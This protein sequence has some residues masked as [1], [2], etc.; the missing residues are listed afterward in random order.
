M[1]AFD[2]PEYRQQLR[3]LA[4]RGVFIGTSSWKYPGWCGQIYD[5]QRYLTRDKFSESKFNRECLA[6][7]AQTFSTVCVDAGYYKFPSASYI[8]GLCE[9]V[10]EGF[11]FAF[12]VTDEITI[13]K[14]PN[15]PRFGERAGT[16]NSNFL[17]ADLFHRLFLNPCDP[18]RSI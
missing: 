5:E 13:K 12:K 3:E 16:Q 11:Q 7:Y 8:A 9:Q 6:E 14:F 1:M 17:D 2:L 4:D 15:L 10:P 18:H